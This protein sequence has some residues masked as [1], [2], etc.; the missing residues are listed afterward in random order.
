MAWPGAG[1]P[2]PQRAVYIPCHWAS[3]WPALCLCAGQRHSAQRGSSVRGGC[4]WGGGGGLW[5]RRHPPPPRRRCQP[6][7]C[8]EF[9]V[10]PVHHGLCQLLALFCS[11]AN[12]CRQH[13]PGHGR[14]GRSGSGRG[15]GSSAGSQRRG[16][17][18]SSSNGAR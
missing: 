16:A 5:G 12:Q 10:L 15:R 7:V 4:A 11:A 13:C 9:S 3:K 8:R 18:A 17:A 2:H 6:G 1:P 14:R